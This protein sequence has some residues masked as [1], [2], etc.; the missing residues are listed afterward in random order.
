MRFHFYLIV[1][2]ALFACSDDMVNQGTVCRICGVADR[3]PADIVS[4]EN[5][6]VSAEFIDVDNDG[7]MDMALGSWDDPYES[8]ATWALRDRLLLNDGS[9]YFTDAAEGAMPFK[10]FN[11]AFSGATGIAPIDANNDGH[12][13]MVLASFAGDLGAQKK[14]QLLINN[15]DGTFRDETNLIPGNVDPHQGFVRVV[16]YNLDGKM[17]FWTAHGIWINTGAGFTKENIGA[18]TLADI[19]G[20]SLPDPVYLSLINDEF[21]FQ[22]QPEIIGGIFSTLAFD[23]D[24]DGDNDLFIAQKDYAQGL[25][26]LPVKL[27]LNDG[28]GNFSY[29]DDATFV[30]SPPELFFPE[31]I[32]GDFNGD[33]L[34]DVYIQEGGTD[35]EPYPGGQN[36]IM[37]QKANG[38]FTDETSS[39]LPMYN[40]FSHGVAIGDI[41]NDGDIDIFNNSIT[42]GDYVSPTLLINDGNGFFTEEW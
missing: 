14:L 30:P 5:I 31:V 42:G 11:G 4:L 34:M 6:Y 41:D 1:F 20:D 10:I 15:G 21:F 24:L 39:R 35:L 19:D 22:G 9:G 3:L 25:I 29:A 32:A 40:D 16:D 28:N 13:D 26:A 8:E 2:I 23:A 18:A 38:T 12:M 17:D 33:G 36:R 27:L 7:D 37:I